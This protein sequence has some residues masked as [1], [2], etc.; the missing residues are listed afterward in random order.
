VGVAPVS[1]E[2]AEQHGAHDVE[3]AAAAVAG[4]VERAIAQELF[5][6]SAGMQELE[7]ED[8]LSFSSDGGLVIP[9]GVI[10]SARGVQGP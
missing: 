3:R 8:Q 6:P 10:A 5:P 9:L 7:E 4:V 2:H 1:G